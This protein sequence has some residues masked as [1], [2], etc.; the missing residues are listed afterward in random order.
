MATVRMT[1]RMSPEAAQSLEAAFS[2][3]LTMGVDV[4]RTRGEI[5]VQGWN[6][7]GTKAGLPV[8]CETVKPWLEGIRDAIATGTL[9]LK[10]VTRCGGRRATRPSR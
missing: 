5:E 9:R 8:R 7:D 4:G 3:G 1:D 2:G 10:P 6:G